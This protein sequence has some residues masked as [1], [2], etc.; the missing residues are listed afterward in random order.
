MTTKHIWT[1]EEKA[2]MREHYPHIGGAEMVTLLGHPDIT[3]AKVYAKANALGLNKAP[4][5]MATSASGR[6]LKG[7]KRGQATQ[8]KLGHKTWNAGTAGT[9]L[10]GHHPNTRATQFKPGQKPHTTLPVGSFRVVFTKGSTQGLLEQKFHEAPGGPSNR[11]R[12]Y[13]RIVWERAHGPIAPGHL[14][15]FKP[16]MATVKPEE[17]TVDRLECIT[18]AENMRRNTIHR[19]PEAL[20]SVVRLRGRLTRLIGQLEGQEEALKEEA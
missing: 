1:E 16:G 15:V 19:M 5:W 2:L 12:F 20:A 3:L 9:G 7:G 14:I 10:T 4:E 17:M 6:L 8:F 13:G 18:R 11:W